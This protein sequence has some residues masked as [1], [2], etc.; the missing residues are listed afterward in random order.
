MTEETQVLDFNTYQEH[1][2]KTAIYK[3]QDRVIYPAL[4][5][6]GEAGEVCGKVSKVL[7][8]G[9]GEMSEEQRVA[10]LDETADVLW[11]LAALCTDLG[12]SL[13]DVAK[14]NLAKLKDR[15][16]RGKIGGSGDK[17]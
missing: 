17:R 2:K 8:D 4:G 5:L 13:E 9:N 11:M 3:E 16:E 10:I 6:A 7:R 14:H 12:A 1:C 15:A